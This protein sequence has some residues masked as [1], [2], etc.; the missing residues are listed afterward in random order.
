MTD[1]RIPGTRVPENRLHRASLWLEDTK[2]VR[3][4]AVVTYD[5]ETMVRELGELADACGLEL[6][7]EQLAEGARF[8]ADNLRRVVFGGRMG[9]TVVGPWGTM[10][11]GAVI[12]SVWLDGFQH[13]AATAAGKYGE[14]NDEILRRASGD[15]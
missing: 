7:G 10:D 12:L 11:L 3:A 2:R 13:G 9:V 15:D 6:S 1:D 5:N 4:G 14:S 8:Y